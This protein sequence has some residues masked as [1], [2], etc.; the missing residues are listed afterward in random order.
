VGYEKDS[1]IEKEENWRA[2]AAHRGWRCACCAQIL[3]REE[4][5]ALGNMCS[6]CANSLS[7]E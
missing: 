7:E 3:S 4:F 2:L 1:A 6:A 5:E